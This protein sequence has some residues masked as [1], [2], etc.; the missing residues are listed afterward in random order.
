MFQDQLPTVITLNGEQCNGDRIAAV[1]RCKIAVAE[2]EETDRPDAK[3]CGRCGQSVFK[4][5]DFDGFDRAVAAR[6]CV[7]G[8][9][10]LGNPVG[11]KTLGN[12]LGRA[13]QLHYETGG[14]LA[15]D[16]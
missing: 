5:V 4:V 11:A 13:T 15:W 2:L 16:T 3:H 6:G 12:F 1:Y 8:P 7:W 10:D 9:Q 14:P